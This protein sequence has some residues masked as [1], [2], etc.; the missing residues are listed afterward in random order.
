ME[1][2]KTYAERQLERA[3][4]LQRQQEM[5]S[6]SGERPCSI[7][8]AEIPDE[9]ARTRPTRTFVIVGITIVALLLIAQCISLLTSSAKGKKAQKQ[10]A[11]EA[12][13]RK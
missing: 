9:V 12:A 13:E 10:E 2:P 8:A 1:R 11:S 7:T 5:L 4:A 6:G 3:E